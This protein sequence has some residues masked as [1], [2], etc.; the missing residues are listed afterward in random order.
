MKT[1]NFPIR[2]V[3]PL[4]FSAAAC[5][6]GIH[7]D[8]CGASYKDTVLA[9][10]PLAYYRLEEAAGAGTLEDSSAT[11]AYAGTYN[12]TEDGLYPTLEL[13]GIEV[14]SGY[15]K[16]K[17]GSGS[18][19]EVPYAAELNPAANF[20]AEVWVRALSFGEDSRCPFGSFGGW[21]G[22]APGWFFYQLGTT[23]DSS[24][25]VL[26]MKG[27]GIWLQAPTSIVK[28]EWF[29]LAMTFDGSNLKFYVNATLV[30]SSTVT[31][32]APNPDRPLTIGGSKAGDWGF[33]GN[34]DEAA[35]YGTV[36]SPEQI[37]QHFKVGQTSFR[38]VTV[39]PTVT[40]NPTDTTVYAGRIAKFV[41]G[42]DGTAPFAFQWFKNGAPIAGATNDTLVVTPTDSDNGSSYLAKI[43]NTIGSATSQSA[44]LSV[45]TDLVLNASPA[46]VTREVG[47]AV[48]LWPDVG[49]ALPITGYQWS[50]NG[51]P[52]AGATNATLWLAAVN[53]SDD[54][55][56]FTV[57][58][59]NPWNSIESEPAALTVI[60]RSVSVPMTGYAAKVL[61]DGP[62]AYWRLNESSGSD[63]AVDAIGSFNGTFKSGKDSASFTFQA[64]TGVPKESD[65]CLSVSNGAHVSV[66]YALELNPHGPFTVEAW[67]KPSSLG[68]FSDDYR[69]PLAA[70]GSGP[71][72]WR[73]YQQPNHTFALVLFNDNWTAQ[74][75][76]A[77]KVTISSGTWYHIVITRTAENLFSLYIN[78]ELQAA[79]VYDAYNPS[80]SDGTVD[81]GWHESAY[82]P[83]D[84]AIDEVAFYNKALAAD[85]VFDHFGAVK[86][87]ISLAPAGVVLTWSSGTL[88]AATSVDGA[89]TD[90]AGA[91][92]PATVRPTSAATFYRVKQ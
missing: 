56:T 70:E 79:T 71:T 66:P 83:Y 58:V 84:G 1:R 6:L 2:T 34:V 42:V 54:G 4:L 10:Q 67:L 61:K 32:Y 40:G 33:D 82:N 39:P 5:G 24:P 31:D 8:V 20:S 37:A 12:Y 14:N 48:A 68:G 41:V 46:S 89:F 11:A 53:Q 13:P 91:T 55:A 35:F 92:S 27:G 23:G 85:Q 3:F 63:V 47:S 25:W 49:G 74:W 7:Q 22:G 28:N 65:V 18:S 75:L 38:V 21:D 72:G 80:R 60:E 30:A 52:I 26:V 78:G 77:N 88:Q 19:A 64:P 36:L 76:Y 29:Y 59:T 50:K 43:T 45:K 17:N 69:S 16:S 62:I 15:F 86:L 73:L 51:A 87:N 57:R 81:F 90:V 9:D 44:T